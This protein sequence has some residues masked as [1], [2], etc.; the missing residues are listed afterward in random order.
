MTNPAQRAAAIRAFLKKGRSAAILDERFNSGIVSLDLD[1]AARSRLRDWPSAKM[2]FAEADESKP[3]F[4]GNKVDRVAYQPLTVSS[5]ELIVVFYGKRTLQKSSKKIV[6]DIL[7]CGYR[8]ATFE[9]LL[10]AAI[11]QP[12]TFK[13]PGRVM[14]LGT[15]LDI[16]AGE[17]WLSNLEDAFVPYLGWVADQRTLGTASWISEWNEFDRFLARIDPRGSAGK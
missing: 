13:V 10:A 2:A 1:A 15:P 9:E 3:W 14:A 4:T 6:A 11:L 16:Q 5:L 7:R 8:P 17:G 12:S